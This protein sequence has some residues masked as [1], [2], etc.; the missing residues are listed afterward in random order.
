MRISRQSSSLQIMIDQK[1]LENV[2]YCNYLSSV[3]TNDVRCMCEIKPRTATVKAE[4]KRRKPL[5]T[6]ELD[7]NL[8][9]K[10]VKC[11]IWKIA[12]HVAETWALKKVCYIYVKRFD[13]WLD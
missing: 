12:L 5:F 9:K 10:L 7:L 2:E 4:L 11:Y 3:I 6:R 8:K 1:Q 13:M